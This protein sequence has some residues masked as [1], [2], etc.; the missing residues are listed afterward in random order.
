MHPASENEA[1][2]TDNPLEPE[3]AA[4]DSALAAFCGR[5]IE[6]CWLMAC[7]HAAV[8]DGPA[9]RP[10]VSTHQNGRVE[11]TGPNYD[12]GACGPTCGRTVSQKCPD[13]RM[14]RRHAGAAVIRD[15]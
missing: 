9:G 5:L 1:A 15:G 6:A 3:A 2:G 8:A 7:W 10:P 13:S 4:D 11:L 12:D 14:A